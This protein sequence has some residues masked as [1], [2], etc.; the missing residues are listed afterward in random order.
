MWVGSDVPVGLGESGSRRESPA[1]GI[2]ERRYF[3]RVICA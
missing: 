1:S 2:S 3:W